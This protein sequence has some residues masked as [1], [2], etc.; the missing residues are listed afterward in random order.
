MRVEIFAVT[1]E[2]AKWGYSFFIEATVG[3]NIHKTLKDCLLIHPLN[4]VKA[5]AKGSLVVLTGGTLILKNIFWVA[6]DCERAWAVHA[7]EG[8]NWNI[9]SDSDSD[10]EEE[11]EK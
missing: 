2:K 11:S 3:N 7:L 8:F 6:G 4:E 9:D 1:N 5:L 10:S